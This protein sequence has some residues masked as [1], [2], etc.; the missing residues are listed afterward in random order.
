MV[1]LGGGCG[2]RIQRLKALPRQKWPRWM[3]EVEQ[4]SGRLGRRRGRGMSPAVREWDDCQRGAARNF[5]PHRA[6]GGVGLLCVPDKAGAHDSSPFLRRGRG[7]AT[8]GRSSPRGYPRR[9]GRPKASRRTKPAGG[10]GREAGRLDR[11]QG[12]TRSTARVM[13]NR[14]W[15]LPFSARGIVQSPNDFGTPRQSRR[16]TPELLDYLA[17][18]I[19]CQGGWSV[20]GDAPGDHGCR[21]TYQLSRRP[22]NWAAAQTDPK[23]RIPSGISAGHRLGRRA[24]PR[25]GLFVGSA[26]RPR[27]AP[28]RR[29]APPSRRNRTGHYNAARRRFS[30]RCTKT[31]PPKRPTWMQQ[32]IKAGNPLPLCGIS[33]APEPQTAPQPAG[34]AAPA[35]TPLQAALSDE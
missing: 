1:P 6:G 32:R 11:R 31:K 33:T 14:I 16:R 25:R 22:M 35:T 13:V 17:R 2:R 24:D 20:K 30:G 3:P 7:G 34:T 15:Q 4:L 12:P 23:R 9:A 28:P 29:P 10:P 26:A 18:E 21:P 8:G 27:I 19:H 5:A